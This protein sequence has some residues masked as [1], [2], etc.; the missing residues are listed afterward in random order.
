MESGNPEAPEHLVRFAGRVDGRVVATSA[1]LDR[2]GVAGMY[3]VA[4]Q[5]RFRRRGI[6]AALTWAA[7]EEGRRRGLRVAT[8][9]ASPM[10][11][12][13]YE[14]LGFRTVVDYRLFQLG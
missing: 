4:T 8:L 1:L 13:V 10:G 14:R 2:S 11:R 7:I 9:Q 12:P 3:V 6:G 5:E